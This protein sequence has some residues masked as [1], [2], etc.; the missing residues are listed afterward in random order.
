MSLSEL[1]LPWREAYVEENLE[2]VDDLESGH[3]RSTFSKHTREDQLPDNTTST[4][5][6]LLTGI[7]NSHQI[8]GYA[9]LPKL[10]SLLGNGTLLRMVN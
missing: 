3:H 5:K 8:N 10:Q 1:R 9:W 2:L 7:A 6:I 4:C